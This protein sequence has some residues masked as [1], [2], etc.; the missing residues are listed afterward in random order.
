MNYLE[1]MTPE[2]IEYICSVIPQNKVVEYFKHNSKHFS[3]LAPGFRAKSFERNILNI[4]EFLMKHHKSDFISSF[5]EKV[6]SMWM[7]QIKDVIQS[8]TNEGVDYEIALLKT[9]PISYFKD[10]VKLFVKLNTD[11][12]NVSNPTMLQ[13]AIKEITNQSTKNSD[14]ISQLKESEATINRLKSNIINLENK[15]ENDQSTIQNLKKEN[16]NHKSLIEEQGKRILATDN[17]LKKEVEKRNTLQLDFN[18]RSKDKAKELRKANSDLQKIKQEHAD[19]LR[20]IEKKVQTIKELQEQVERCKRRT[21]V[22]EEEVAKSNELQNRYDS[23]LNELDSKEEKIKQLL[24]QIQENDRFLDEIGEELDKIKQ[25]AENRAE[26]IEDL[27]R[28]LNASE[29][30]SN[31]IN[32]SEQNNKGLQELEKIVLSFWEALEGYKGTHPES[33][34]SISSATNTLPRIPDTHYP[35]TRP[36]MPIDM[37]EFKQRL[38][39]FLHS[40]RTFPDA[41]SLHSL[42]LD[43]VCD[44]IFCGVPIV[45]TRNSSESLVRGIAVA[46]SGNPN[47]QKLEY[48]D[49]ITTDRI[50]HFISDAGRIVVIDNFI[51]N[52]NETLLMPLLEKHKDKIIFITTATNRSLNYVSDEFLRYFIYLNCEIVEPIVSNQVIENHENPI[53]EMEREDTGGIFGERYLKTMIE[54]TRELTIPQSLAAFSCGKLKNHDDIYK[55]LVFSILPYSRFVKR[56]SPFSMSQ[57]LTRYVDRRQH[58][59]ID[60]VKGWLT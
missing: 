20:D 49:G 15:S 11:E 41:N 26:E 37:T 4:S 30:L 32:G 22:L 42:F 58:C 25:V 53:E 10:N 12:E 38:R 34:I 55:M 9:L 50:H 36:R 51:G 7:E 35:P 33:L 54:I 31:T 24:E 14:L 43:F 17:K 56:D 8:H 13:H 57:K 3:Q 46:L 28:K 52:Y 47:Y 19:A 23:I 16:R 1:I 29:E 45:I 44:I 5:I 6:I 21:E 60:E 39:D 59:A 27:T 48:M 40:S 2:E 18:Q